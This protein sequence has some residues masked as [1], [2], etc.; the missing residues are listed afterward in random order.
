MSPF[1]LLRWMFTLGTGVTLGL[2]EESAGDDPFK[3]FGDVALLAALRE[4]E[5]GAAGGGTAYP[6]C[7]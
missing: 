7:W 4:F 2:S 3:L 6:V 1:S 5:L